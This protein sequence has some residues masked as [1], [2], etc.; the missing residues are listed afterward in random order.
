MVPQTLQT[1]QQARQDVDE[2]IREQR[3]AADIFERT[4]LQRR[5]DVA[6]MCLQ[7]DDHVGERPWQML[8]HGD[9]KMKHVTT[10]QVRNGPSMLRRQRGSG[11][12][13]GSTTNTTVRGATKANRTRVKTV[14][15]SPRQVGII[16]AQLALIRQLPN[17]CEFGFEKGMRNTAVRRPCPLC[18]RAVD[19]D[20]GMLPVAGHGC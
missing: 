20:R 7:I 18:A 3:A 8:R 16:H 15:G 4:L 1:R 6:E 5:V 2:H 17:Q 11:D 19:D 14:G 9:G 13:G 10:A 12:G